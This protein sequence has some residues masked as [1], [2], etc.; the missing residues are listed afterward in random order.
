MENRCKQHANN[1]VF[2]GPNTVTGHLSVIY[3]VECQINFIL[4]LI[5]PLIKSKQSG[6][7]LLSSAPKTNIVDVKSEA[8][9]NDS[10]WMQKEL[11]KLVWASG[12][13]NWALDP[14]TGMNIAM[15]PG[16]QFTFWW[17][18]VFIP[19]KDFEYGDEKGQRKS[20]TVGGW[21]S[22]RSALSTTVVVAALVGGAMSMRRTGRLDDLERVVRSGLATAVKQGQQLLKN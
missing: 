8:A 14:N 20:F 19:G 15:Y 18:S 16:Y 4:R 2:R 7:S 12:C 5:E 21:K 13:T 9:K 6:R 11:R 17:R 10:S 22:L 1:M 3:T